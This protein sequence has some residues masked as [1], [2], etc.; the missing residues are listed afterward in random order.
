VSL[1]AIMTGRK[2]EPV[3]MQASFYAEYL[4]IEDSHWWFRGRR[5]VLADLLRRH[6]DS[7][8]RLLDVGSSGGSVTQA[9]MELGP[10][11][12]C[13]LDLRSAAAAGRWPGLSPVVG[14]AE[15]LP[16]EDHSFD[17]VT[18]FDVIEH[19]DDDLGALQEIARV[20]RPT[21]AVAIAVPAY[22]WMWG[23]QDEVNGHRRRYTRW[24]LRRRLE[25]AGLHVERMTSFN[26]FLFP[27]IAT[28][29][30]LRRLY[31]EAGKGQDRAAVARSDFSMTR[32]GKMN[33]A[34]SVIFGAERW[35][36]RVMD[37]PVGV[38][39]FAF[40]RLK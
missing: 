35:I 17:L 9:L 5:L 34:L 23:R 24:L 31:R 36:L 30:L 2:V 4:E 37:L 39:L 26:S 15:A 28:I 20:V 33:E 6:V 3:P 40:T 29:R 22:E 25:A 27:P 18:A 10:V 16:F 11:T 8:L 13:D 21:G 1:P 12:A 14:R 38:S 7:R 19:I 32:P